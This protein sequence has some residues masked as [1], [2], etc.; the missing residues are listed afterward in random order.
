M[1]APVSIG[2]AHAG[3][4]PALPPV[5]AKRCLNRGRVCAAFNHFRTSGDVNSGLTSWFA[6]LQTTIKFLDEKAPLS[7]PSWAG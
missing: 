5:I 2:G 3:R 4:P 1:S 6:N 7:V